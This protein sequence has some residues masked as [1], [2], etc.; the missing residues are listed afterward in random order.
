LSTI[1]LMLMIRT[2]LKQKH[3]SFEVV[4]EYLDGSG[5]VPSVVTLGPARPS[6]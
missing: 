3:A 1:W 4:G 2:K 6:V 5:T